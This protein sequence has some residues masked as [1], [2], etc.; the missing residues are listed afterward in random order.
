MKLLFIRSILEHDWNRL[1]N[2]SLILAVFYFCVLVAI[3]VDLAA[4]VEKAKRHGVMRTSFGFRRTI[5]KIKDYFSV[6]MLFTVAD[7][8]A[9]VWFS[10]PFFT[11]VGT[12][13]M[14]FIEA[15]SVYENKKDIN[16]GIKDLPDVLLQILRNK[17]KA[18]EL[19]KFLEDNKNET[20]K[21]ETNHDT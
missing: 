2:L 14:V 19:L 8:V 15:K 20:P 17:D 3:F 7:I 18:E 5:N 12:I 13:A 21:E 16:K 9:S 10:L 6:L 1:Q 4:G 11:A